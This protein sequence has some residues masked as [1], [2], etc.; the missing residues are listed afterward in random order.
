MKCTSI[1]LKWKKDI[2]ELLWALEA[3]LKW[4]DA[5]PLNTVLPVMPGFDRDEVEIIIERA[6][7][8]VSTPK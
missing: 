5:V 8:I 1:K 4:I 7:C 6:K 3:T 2:K